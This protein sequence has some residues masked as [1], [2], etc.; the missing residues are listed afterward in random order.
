MHSFL[1]DKC[2]CAC[3]AKEAPEGCPD[4]IAGETQ[5]ALL[6]ESRSE[7]PSLSHSKCTCSQ[8]L[9]HSFPRKRHLKRS[10]LIVSRPNPFHQTSPPQLS[11]RYRPKFPELES[12]VL[13]PIDFARV[14]KAIGN[15]MARCP[16]AQC[17]AECKT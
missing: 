13:H 12:L 17:S 4:A 14:V 9:S 6:K 5:H 3:A 1:R 2:A 16:T 11:A 8:I 10:S 7:V 15:E